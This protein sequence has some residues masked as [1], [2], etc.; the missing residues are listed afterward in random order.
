M[1]FIHS[2]V[3]LHWPQDHLS[4]NTYISQ[5]VVWL[6]WAAGLLKYKC[7][8]YK[9]FM[10]PTFQIV[11]MRKKTTFLQQQVCLWLRLFGTI[12]VILPVI[13]IAGSAREILRVP[14][15]PEKKTD[16]NPWS[17]KIWN[18]N[19]HPHGVVSRYS[20]PQLQVGENYLYLFNPITTST[21]VAT[22]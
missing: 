17:A 18:L 22:A 1:W 10:F 15:L 19:F 21:G 8:A 6:W 14:D 5:P 7:T 20:D 16:G 12:C 13:M 9:I 3:D 4:A 11:L 2:A